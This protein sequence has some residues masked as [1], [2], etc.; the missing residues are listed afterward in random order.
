MNPAAYKTLLLEARG[1]VARLTLNRPDRLNAMS[2]ELMVELLAAL[3]AVAADRDARCLMIT[4]AGRGFCAGADLAG[5][6][7]NAGESDLSRVLHE[8][9]HPV[10]RRLADFPLPVVCAVNGMAAGGGMSLALAADITIAARSAA[11]LQA[12][13][14]IGL[15]PDVGS[16][17]FLPRSGGTARALGL[18][19]LGQRIS[20]EDAARLGLIWACV[21]DADLEAEAAALAA[22]LA[23]GSRAA[24][25]ATR[26]LMREGWMKSLDTQLEA[27]ARAQRD[28]GRR[29][30]F[31]E[32]VAAFREKRAPA[33]GR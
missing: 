30:D 28:A 23:S 15:V 1:G 6:T 25:V 26:R 5:G 13:C 16:T 9:Y 8:W 18:A 33:F 19:M 24:L 11:F 14:N 29:P 4:G 7:V 3:E 21:A 32:G 10:V 12:F 17:W 27:E 22:R 31:Q 20:A 2:A